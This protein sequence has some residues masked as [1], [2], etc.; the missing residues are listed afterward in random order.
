MRW[1]V[2]NAETQGIVLVLQEGDL[3]EQNAILEGGGKGWGDQTGLEQWNAAKRAFEIL[4][5]R[6]PYIL[7]T[8]NHDYG[9]R[10]AES[11]ETHFNEF[12]RP[13]D[14][15][16]VSDGRRRGNPAWHGQQRVRRRDPGERL[17][18]VQRSGRT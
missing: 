6:L 2:D 17:L 12:F 8:G 15:S 5:G 1:I 7:C 18:R 3:V 4:D 16:L 11:R 13:T 10:R 9:E 14:N